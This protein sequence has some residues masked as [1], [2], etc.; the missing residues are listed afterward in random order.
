ML[1][2]KFIQI[3]F[4]CFLFSF[5][6]FAKGFEEGKSYISLNYGKND[7][8]LEHF[9]HHRDIVN[10]TKYLIGP[11]YLKYEK[12]VKKR[13]GIGFNSAYDFSTVDFYHI[14]NTPSGQ[15]VTNYDHVK[16][17]SFSLLVRMNYHL[18]SNKRFDPYIGAGLGYRWRTWSFT[19]TDVNEKLRLPRKIYL[20]LG[21]DLTMGFRYFV[22]QKIA[23]ECEVGIAKSPFQFGITYRI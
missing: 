3:L 8:A 16:Y 9:L 11:V 10:P 4:L 17:K 7:F 19:S 23:I 21:F 15:A 14:I 6:A 1:N 12:A 13:W 18:L 5:S 22:V 2:S 20:P